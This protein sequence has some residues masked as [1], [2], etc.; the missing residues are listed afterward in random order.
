MKNHDLNWYNQNVN[1]HGA[2]IKITQPD[3]WVMK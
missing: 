1:Q 3:K 2:A